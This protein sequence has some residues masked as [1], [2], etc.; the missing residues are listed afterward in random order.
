MPRNAPTKTNTLQTL[1]RGL[2]ALALIATRPGGWSVAEL[3]AELE[4]DVEDIERWRAA[5]AR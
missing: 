5:A 3:A 2:Q 1:D 4:A